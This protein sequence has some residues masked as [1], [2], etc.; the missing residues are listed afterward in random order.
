MWSSNSDLR[1][2]LALR[3]VVA[4]YLAVFMVSCRR[5]CAAGSWPGY[6]DPGLRNI[7]PPSEDLTTGRLHL[8]TPNQ[9]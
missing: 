3:S 2:K 7:R 6:L 5:R 4:L 8:I 1:F 9:V